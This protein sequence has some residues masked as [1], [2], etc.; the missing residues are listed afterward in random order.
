MKHTFTLHGRFPTARDPIPEKGMKNDIAISALHPI[1]MARLFKI[2]LGHAQM[3]RRVTRSPETK[4][5]RDR[6]RQ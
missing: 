3:S 1:S 2:L 6:M 4:T 5:P